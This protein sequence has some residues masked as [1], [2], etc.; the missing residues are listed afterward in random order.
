MEAMM[1]APLIGSWLQRQKS[2]LAARR[3]VALISSGLTLILALGAWIDFSLLD[4]PQAHDLWPLLS[5]LLGQEWLIVDALSSPLLP[6]AALIHFLVILMTPPTKRRR[7]P[8][9]LVL[10]METLVLLLFACRLPE[11]ILLLMALSAIPPWMDLKARGHATGLFWMHTLTSLALMVGGWLLMESDPKGGPLGPVLLM[12]GLLIRAGSVPFH[13]W[14]A[15]LFENASFGVAILHV[16]PMA[17]AYAAIRLIL[18]DAPDLLMDLLGVLALVTA[19]YSAGMALVQQEARRF[20]CFLF[21]SHSSLVWLGLEVISPLGWTAGL[22]VWISV[23]LCMAGFGLTLRAVESRVGYLDWKHYRGLYR[24]M[25]MLAIFFLL[26][27]LA[28]IGFPGSIGFIGMEMLVESALNAYPHVGVMVLLA[29]ALNG[30]AVLA[31]YFRIF[32][33]SIHPGSISLAAMP[34]EKW[35]VGILGILIIGV[36]LAPQSGVNSRYQAAME[37]LT[38]ASNDT[39]IPSHDQALGTLGSLSDGMNPNH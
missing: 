31:V 30:I 29:A 28:C 6:L 25:P 38:P 32:T 34:H 37:L 3:K 35:A 21:L 11:G 26:S 4:V 36:G 12:M 27:G 13:L 20:F 15:D 17:S 2:Q 22:C 19:L 18:P 1:I 5:M 9:G 7:F 24:H 14:V 23:S 10:V 33:G 39:W 16:T 8:Y